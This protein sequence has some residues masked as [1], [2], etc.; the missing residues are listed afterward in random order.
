M[1]RPQATRRSAITNGTGLQRR[2]GCHQATPMHQ[3]WQEFGI[4]TN[5]IQFTSREHLANRPTAAVRETRMRSGGLHPIT[6]MQACLRHGRSLLMNARQRKK[7]APGLLQ[8]RGV[9]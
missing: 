7:R 9:Q 1:K 6:D 8:E 4:E 5:I 3:P 2:R